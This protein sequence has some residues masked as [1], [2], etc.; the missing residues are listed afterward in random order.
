MM[1]LRFSSK[2]MTIIGVNKIDPILKI[3]KDF[4]LT[5]NILLLN[6]AFSI[7]NESR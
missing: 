6:G 5:I 7:N 4:S 3:N 2:L 1:W